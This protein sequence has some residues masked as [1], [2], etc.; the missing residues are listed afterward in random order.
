VIEIQSSAGDTRLGGDDFDEVLAELVS[1]QLGRDRGIDE[2]GPS[3]RARVRDACELAK[4]RLSDQEVARVALVGLGSKQQDVEVHLR[5]DQ[6]EN[7]WRPLID[8]MRAP[9][10][11]ALADANLKPQQIDEI[12]LVGGATRMPCVARLAADMFGRL[13]LRKLPPD[14]AVAMGAAV[15]AALKARDRAVDD[16]VVTDV[17]PFTLGISSGVKMGTDVVAGL[18][19][20]IIERGTVIPCSRVKRF[21]TLENNQSAIQVDVFQGEHP[22]CEQN[23]RLAQYKMSLPRGKAGEES[24]DVRFTYDLNGILEVDTTV[25]STGKSH[26]MVIEK[27]PGHLSSEQVRQARET[28]KALKFHPRDSLPNKTALARADAL[29]VDST[30]AEREMLGDLIAGLKLAI[31]RQEPK[32]IDEVRQNLVSLTETLRSRR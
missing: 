29:Y 23:T 13:P 19:A 14:E 12:L 20:P 31:E 10:R 21:F 4:K 9:I 8:R 26:S 32:L 6:A 18:F 22:T 17:A 3:G 7:S 30:G 2:L 28:M 1:C 24:I 11:R 5:R 27:S 16:L 15:Q 25:V